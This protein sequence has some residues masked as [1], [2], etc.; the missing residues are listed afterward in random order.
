MAD[1][2]KAYLA[3]KYM[4]GPKAD[5]ILARASTS[6]G[7]PKKKKRKVAA[8]SATASTSFINDDDATGWAVDP[9]DP[10]DDDIAEAAVAASDRAFRKRQ[11]TDEGSGWATVKEPESV[12]ADEQ[13]QVVGEPEE[14]EFKGGLM[15]AAQLKKKFG[16]SAVKEDLTAEE[17]AAAQETVYR[18]ATGRKVDVAVERAE[19]ARRKR[20]REEKEAKKMEWGKGL[21]QRDEQER[22]KKELEELKSRPFARTID[23]AAMNEDMKAQDRW[24]DPAAAFLT[25]KRTKGPRKP[26]YTGPPP[27]PNRFGIKPGYRWDGVDR[28]NG[29]EKKLFQRQNEKKRRGQESYQWS[30]DEM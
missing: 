10:E 25:K 11:R 20:E 6:S 26:E 27:P 18:D 17:I 29:F 14:E 19:A 12:P 5:A 21:V 16:K 24:N 13:P 30:V 28:G 7:A 1:S 15:T 9:K 2:M 23:D 8:S 3:S 4:S 22:K